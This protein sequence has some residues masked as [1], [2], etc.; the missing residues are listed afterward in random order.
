MN[1]LHLALTVKTGKAY[2]L[3]LSRHADSV[4]K[5][6]RRSI[7]LLRN[8]LIYS[9][10]TDEDVTVWMDVDIDV[11]PPGLVMKMAESGKDIITPGCNWGQRNGDYDQNAWKGKRLRPSAEELENLAKGELFV[12]RPIREGPGSVRFVQELK[13]EGVDYV[14]LDSVGG[15]L[16]FVK[17]EI[18][19]KGISFP[20]YYVIGAD[21]DLMEGWDGIETEGI[22]YVARTAGYKCWGMPNH[23]TSPTLTP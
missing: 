17:A 9:T 11:L 6:R 4:Q 13:E 7:A 8:T 20:P 18:F 19:R 21:W 15:T 12:P 1:L 14:E 10:L 22:C 2:L 5:E 16:L 3:T 23:G